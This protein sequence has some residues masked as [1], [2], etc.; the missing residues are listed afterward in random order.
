MKADIKPEMDI[1]LVRKNDVSKVKGG[2]SLGTAIAA[3]KSDLNA[4]LINILPS[5]RDNIISAKCDLNIY[6]I[7]QNKSQ[8]IV[9]Q[10]D[11]SEGLGDTLQNL[12]RL[13]QELLMDPVVTLG[14]PPSYR[15]TRLFN[16]YA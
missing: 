16:W 12:E 3:N 11:P 9:Q 6:L 1:S 13:R 4:D 5:Y 8:Q 2:D 10:T 15:P 7:K 14:E